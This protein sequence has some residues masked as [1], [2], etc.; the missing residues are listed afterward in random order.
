MVPSTSALNRTPTSTELVSPWST[1]HGVTFGPAMVQGHP[2]ST[3]MLGDD[4]SMLPLSSTARERIRALGAPWAIHEYVHDVVPVAGCHV[5][6]PSAE[7]STPA[8]VPPAS[9]AVPE[10]VTLVPSAIAV[11]CA[12]LVIVEM[13]A[14]VSVDAEVAVNPDI[15]VVAD[16]PMSANRFTVAC[17]MTG[18][19]VA[20]E[21]GP[22]LFHALVVS[23][24]HAH[25][26]VP[27]PKT[28][29]PLAARYIVR[30]C[31]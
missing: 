8:T 3:V 25:C 18:S 27:A 29:A 19:A 12:G 17:C 31:V 15:S 6:P 22:L 14:V 20:P 7:T 21:G 24:P 2:M 11:P 16:A 10:I 5:A 4:A 13:G 9:V 26:T 1:V 30:W 23:R 28:S